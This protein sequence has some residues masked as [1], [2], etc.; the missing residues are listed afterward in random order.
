[1]IDNAFKRQVA[2]LEI[3]SHKAPERFLRHTAW[4]AE[5]GQIFL[6]TMLLL[7]LGG[8]LWSLYGLV[9]VRFQLWRLLLLVG[10]LA[11]LGTLVASLWPPAEV[12]D[13]LPVSPEEAPR[14]YE[15]L[16]VLRKRIQ[17]PELHR[18]LVDDSL[19][20]SIVQ[21]P[22][23]GMLG[24][25]RNTLVLGLPAMM[26]L[27]TSQLAAQVAHEFA[28][29]ASGRRER[30]AWLYRTRRSWWR[31]AQSRA[32]SRFAPGYFDIGARLFFRFFFPRFNARAMVVARQ[33][34][35]DA[36]RLA[37]KV[38]GTVPS[39]RGLVALAVLQRFLDD[40]FWPGIWAQ[41]QKEA[42]PSAKPLR[43][44]YVLLREA[45][46]SPAA[47]RWLRE[48][49]ARVPD[50]TDSHGSL[51]AR[52]DLAEAPK[53]LPEP[54]EHCAA[55]EL[56]S[57]GCLDR[58]IGDLDVL[59]RE[60]VHE[61]WLHRHRQHVQ[62]ALL[63]DELAAAD[64]THP[65]P[66]AELLLWARSAWQVH[67]P[68]VAVDV[69]RQAMARHKVSTEAG[70]L[71]G[72]ALVAT[73]EP[74]QSVSRQ[75]DAPAALLEGM[76]LLIDVAQVEGETGPYVYSDD[77]D[78]YWRLQAARALEKV[79]EQRQLFEALK[80]AR[81]RMRALEKESN[82]AKDLLHDFGGEQV[83]RPAAL[84]PRVLRPVVALLQ[85]QPSVGR[86][87][88]F[89]KTHSQCSGWALQLLVIERSKL[90]GQ[91]DPVTWWQWL[92]DRIQLPLPLIVVDLAHPFW[93]ALARAD[94][95]AQFRNADAACIYHGGKA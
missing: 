29:L 26:G 80:H 30:M 39:A 52:L 81:E 53:E 24:R 16:R 14:L 38:M 69:L 94:L 17:A 89:R 72:Q 66:L 85:S 84:S 21:I 77:V 4:M 57:T 2:Q 86:A 18:V 11:L 90:L 60:R 76:E 43:A 78:P 19:G 88:M 62:T 36:D 54:P 50:P 56:L 33:Q 37:H 63:A 3:R 28:H 73:C 65:L 1:V 58:L 15:M 34:E 48:A 12:S 91:P 13:G 74:V 64:A 49:L 32:Q 40:E 82:R 59:W 95:V 42:L 44:Q 7:A 31:M 70:C 22:R 71:L 46:R 67:G 9:F 79:L 20:V 35:L 6:V 55:D 8:L 68:H 41:A 93:K 27:S 83:L 23:L 92:Q 75:P 25:Y 10:F 5:F 61:E 51:R 87:W 45:L 47:A